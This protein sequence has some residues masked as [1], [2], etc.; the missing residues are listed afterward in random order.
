MN[1]AGVT[2]HAWSAEGSN[3]GQAHDSEIPLAVWMA[4]RLHMFE[5][6][7]FWNARPAF[8]PKKGWKLSLGTRLISSPGMMALNGMGGHIAARGCWRPL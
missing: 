4:E 2:C 3:E 1:V 8:L 7:H 6:L 5:T